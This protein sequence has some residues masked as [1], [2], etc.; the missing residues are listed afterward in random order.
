MKRKEIRRLIS[1]FLRSY[2]SLGNGA[3]S[4]SGGGKS[5]TPLQ[6]KL[7]YLDLVSQLPSYGAKCFSTGPPRIATPTDCIERVLLVSP[8]FGLSQIAGGH[9]NVVS[10]F[11]I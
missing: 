11:L 2:S 4:Q 5:L 1:H 6:A 3:P 7:L 8:R 10:I 9:N